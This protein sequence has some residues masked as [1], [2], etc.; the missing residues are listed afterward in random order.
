MKNLKPKT[1]DRKKFDID[2]AYAEIREQKLADIFEK[3]KIELK[4]ERDLWQKTG[5]IVIEY[6]CYGKPSGISTTE[7]DHW[8]H[9]LCIG[10]ETFAYIVF[11][12]KSLKKIINNLDYKKTVT[13]GDNNASRLY[14]LNLQ[15][16]FSSDVI[17]AFKGKE[18][19]VA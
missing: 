3:S 1:K 12:T 14:L 18:S 7:S 8:F 19:D 5:N 6:E 11:D 15:K 10:E 13:G 2:L 4:S 17:K 16:L 9:Q